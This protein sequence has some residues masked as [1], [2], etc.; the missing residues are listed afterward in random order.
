MINQRRVVIDQV[1][2]QVNCGN[3]PIKRVIGEIV[4]VNAHLLADG[5][6]IIG[7]SVLYR[8]EN[9]KV[10]K[11]VRLDHVVND[12]WEGSFVVETKGIVLYKVEAWIDYGLTWQHGIERKI[13]AGQNVKSE[14]L[15]GAQILNRIKALAPKDVQSKIEEYSNIFEDTNRYSEA[16]KIANSEDLH[17]IFYSFPERHLS[18]ESK[19]YQIIVDREK[20]AFSTWYEFFPRSSSPET[21]VHGTFKDCE[22]LLP[23]I[24]KM[25]FD[26]LYFPPIHPIGEVNRKGKNNTTTAV[27]GDVGSAWGI[28]SKY[29]GHKD[30]HPDL[31][32]LDDFKSLIKSASNQGIEIAMDYALQA[33]PDHP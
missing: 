23:R 29:G 7:A 1:S 12:E 8:A 3:L 32:S 24:A 17:N 19:E 16:D 4:K 28:G 11:G 18:N 33:A 5:H 21:D 9:E 15:E 25:G 6:D 27:E 14:L 22:R 20:A 2:P 31:G 30:I 10:W 13:E 26:T